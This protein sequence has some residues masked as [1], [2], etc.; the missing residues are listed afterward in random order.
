MHS[1]DLAKTFNEMHMKGLYKEILFFLDTCEGFS[2]FEQITAP[3]IVMVAS[4]DAHESALADSVDGVLNNYE[5]D[6]FDKVLWD[7]LFNGGYQA[8]RNFKISEMLAVFNYD[9]VKSHVT[10][11]TTGRPLDQVYLREYL[12]HN[13]SEDVLLGKGIDSNQMETKFYNWEDLLQ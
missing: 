9:L 1:E 3:N 13:K 7:F 10:M 12:P 2:M 5:Q 8:R 6:A 11:K 4:A